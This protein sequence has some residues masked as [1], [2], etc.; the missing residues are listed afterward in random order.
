MRE[1]SRLLV[2]IPTSAT[3]AVNDKARALRKEGHDI[4]A[5]AGGDPDFDTPDHIVQ[6]AFKAIQDGQT[7]YPAPTKGTPELLQAIAD[8]MV[9]DHNVHVKAGTDIVV[10]SGS[11]WALNLALASVVNPGDE[12]LYFEPVWVSYPPIIRLYDAEPVPIN[13]SSDDNF[14][15]SYDVIREKITPKTK[16]IMVNSP[17]NPTGR[18]LN[19]GEIQAIVNVANEFDLFVI[20]DEVYEKIIFD[21]HTHAA[22]ASEEGMAGRT[23]TVNG[24]SKGYAMTGWRLGW[25]VGPTAVMK[26]AA[27]MNSQTITCAA[28]FTMAAAIAALNGPQD[29]V[30]EMRISYQ[31]RRDFMVKELNAIQGIKCANPD[32]AFYLLPHF[33]DS[34]MNSLQLADYLLDKTGIAATPG[35]AFGRSAEQHLRFSFATAMS[36]LE[37][38]IER[39]AKVV[40]NM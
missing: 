2:R 38:A 21:G 28:T 1:L 10:T 25:L 35:I 17:N 12:V 36:D 23:L 11:K 16:A 34:G 32:G 22:L 27:K 40:P 31:E 6:A 20:T 14:T 8:K 4:I 30:E 7:H 39:L 3:L 26:L 33:P 18:V 13:L 29:A 37:R 24:M 5:L 15:I 9:R 19:R